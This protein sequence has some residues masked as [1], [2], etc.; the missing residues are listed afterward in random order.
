MNVTLNQSGFGTDVNTGAPVSNPGSTIT[1]PPA[2]SVGV[3][4]GSS[5]Q[6]DYTLTNNTFWG[7][8]GLLGA[9]YAV[10]MRMS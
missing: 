7:A 8:D 9:I 1:N 2:F 10:A 5:A 3:T 4:N 6:V